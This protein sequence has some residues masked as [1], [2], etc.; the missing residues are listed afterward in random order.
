MR[1]R[2][3]DVDLESFHLLPK[4]CMASVFWEL[5]QTD[6][7]VDARF[8]KEE[9]FSSTLLEWG[10][11]GKLVVEDGEARAFAQYAPAPL[12]PRLAEYP[13]A[14]AV[15]PDAVYLSY[16]YVEEGRRGRGLGSELIREVARDLVDR[17]YRA[18]ES[19]GDRSWDGSW[20]LPVTFLAS[21]DFAVVRDHPR[22]PLLRLDLRA[23]ARPREQVAEAAVPL[24]SGMAIR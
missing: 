22:Y 23:A 20:V 2:I 12:F 18:V 24:P 10:R 14:A 13:A 11:C 6:A 15:S 16:C 17:G 21:N 7:H 3:V 5:T 8:E 19:I 1:E 4:A 9:W